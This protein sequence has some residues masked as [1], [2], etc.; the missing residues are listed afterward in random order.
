MR[1]PHLPSPNRPFSRWARTLTS[2]LILSSLLSSSAV[3]WAQTAEE[4]TRDLLKNTA[5][6]SYTNPNTNT[7]IESYTNPIANVL[8]PS[9]LDPR[10]RVLGCGGAP[11]DDYTGFTV[12]LYNPDPTD[13]TQSELGG[14]VALT[15]TEVPDIANNSIPLGI[16]PNGSNTNPFQLSNEDQGTY[17][18]LLDPNRGQLGVGQSYILVVTPPT[19]SIYNQRRVRLTITSITPA[20]NRNLVTYTATSLDG[21]PIAAEGATTFEETVTTIGDAERISLQLLALNFSSTLCQINQIQISKSGD[22]ANAAPGDSVIYRLTLRNLSDGALD[23]ITVQDILPTGF[24]LLPNSVRGALNDTEIP[25]TVERNGLNLSLRTDAV[26]PFEGA[27]N[28]VYAAQLTPDAIRGDGR[29]SASVRGFRVDNDLGVRDGPVVHRVRV[30]PGIL[31]DCGNILGRVFVDKNFDGEQQPG[32]PGVPN[33]VIWMDDGN[34]ITTDENGLFHVK[35]V[36]PGPRTGA[37]DLTTLPGYT[38]APNL[39]FIERNSPSRLVKLSPGSTVRMN[40]GVT[41]TFQEE[42]K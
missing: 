4:D 19:A 24:R 41:P 32:E 20:G 21:L 6:Y 25:I 39:H 7:L 33:A 14:L 37:L 35:C 9:L 31:T 1:P 15:R 12:G 26:I 11:L 8:N 40:F 17:S 23:N 30:N 3:T 18:F 34:R 27:I 16:N 10:G 2:A 28:I 36:L 42:A 29:N 5:S 22:R 13:P 38:L